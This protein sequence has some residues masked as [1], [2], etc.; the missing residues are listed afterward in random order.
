MDSAG[1]I[2]IIICM[3]ICNN[4]KEKRRRNHRLEAEQV[5]ILATGTPVLTG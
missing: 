3:Y 1:C 4:K 5:Q 2:Y